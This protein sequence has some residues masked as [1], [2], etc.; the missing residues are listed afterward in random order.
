MTY[1]MAHKQKVADGVTAGVWLIGI[2]ILFATGYWWPGIMFLIGFTAIFQG[3]ARGLPWYS[4]HGGFWAIFIGIWAA[5]GF[6]M[7]FFFISLGVWVILVA[8][9]KPPPFQK[10]AVDNTLE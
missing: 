8:M 10:P 4:V 7:A 6:S 3:W 5:L 1:D 2:G 9:L